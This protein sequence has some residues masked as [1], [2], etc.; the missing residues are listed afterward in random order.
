MQ[1]GAVFPQ[2]EIGS[3]PIVIRDFAQA[4]EDMGFGHMVAYDHVLGAD[5]SNRPDWPGPYTYKHAFH[6]PMTLFSYLAG[7]TKKLQFATGIIILPQRQTALVGKQAANV[8]VFT[9]GRLRM[10]F[11][12]GWNPVEYEALDVPMKDLGS[13]MEEQIDY[14]RHLWTEEVFTF[15]G[16]YHEHH[17]AGLNPMPVQRPIPV[18][19]GGMS[20]AAM[21]RA[22]RMADGWMPALPAEMAQDKIGTF[23][24]AI[25]KAGRDPSTVGVENII[26][27]GATVGGPIRTAEDVV[28]DY[29]LW[30]NAGASHISIHTMTANL[31]NADGH[32]AFLRNVI[33][34]I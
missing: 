11:G 32:L 19:L 10:G 4:L 12:I 26:F 24:E 30:K 23:R 22:A 27:A 18:W 14:L 5:I 29:H 20:D 34:S 13:R 15:E 33:E 7:L 25:V 9:G 2:T 6:E 17:A 1:I 28:S 8:D 21:N 31:G 3:D 16:K